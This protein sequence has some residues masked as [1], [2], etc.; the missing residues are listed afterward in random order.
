M[1]IPLDR[2]SAIPI[3]QQIEEYVRQ[4]ILAGSLAPETRLP[5]TRQLAQDLGISRVTVENAYAVLES[6]G[7]VSRR[8]GSGTYVLPPIVLPPLSQGGARA[9]W[10][11]WQHEALAEP[12]EYVSTEP[13]PDLRHPDPIAFMG[14]GDPRSFP[15]KEFYKAITDVMRRDG[16][17]ALEFADVKGYAPLRATIAHVLASQG[18]QAHPETILITSGSQQALALVAQILL[19][20]GDAVLVEAPTYD[21]AL[22][23]FRAHN[24]KIVGCPTD[25]GGMQVEQLEALLQQQ[26]PKL[27]YSIP[28]FQ[29]PSGACLSAPRRRQLIALA[30]RYNIPIL[31]DDFAGDL[32]YDGRAQPALKAFDPGGRVI[33]V[34]TFSKMLM[35]GLRIGFLVADGPIYHRLAHLKR[36]SDLMT[37]TLMQ[38]ALEEYVTIGRYQAH[39][40]RSCQVY[41]RR[42]DAMLLAIERY[43]PAGAHVSP[44]QGGLFIWLRLPEQLSA[45]KL[46]PLA[47]EEGVRY[48][49]GDRFFPNRSEGQGYLR[50]NFA[51]HTPA[52][53]EEGIR[54]LGRAVQRLEDRG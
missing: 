48:A 54:R 49:P 50:L 43:L 44:P 12:G 8:A 32:R 38:R 21:V 4:S 14:F 5:A 47:A 10:P 16:I 1:R 18:V 29:N 52:E 53:I 26:H 40:R 11:L 9:G 41:R 19:K 46:M 51:T 39:V 45:L 3:Y 6:D 25:A 34:G 42:R 35:P 30:D 17:A 15:V 23:L 36:V 27:I 20:P 7:L 33:Y 31:E 22:E 13:A 2:Q 37:S 28:N 24:L